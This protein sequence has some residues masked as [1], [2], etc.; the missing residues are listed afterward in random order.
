MNVSSHYYT[1]SRLK[2]CLFILLQASNASE[3][4]QEAFQ[5]LLPVLQQAALQT[6]LERAL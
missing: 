6:A 5:L 4:I 2:T 1:P 3:Y